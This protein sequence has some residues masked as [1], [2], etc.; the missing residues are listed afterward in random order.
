MQRYIYFLV[1]FVFIKSVPGQEFSGLDDIVN[2]GIKEKYY[3]GAQLLIG[4]DEKILYIKS[5]GSFTYED[6]TNKVTNESIFDLASLT[7]VVATTTAIM[8]LFEEGKITGDE[9]IKDYI[10]EFDNNGKG[11]IRLSNL[12]LHNSGLPAWK[13]FYKTCKTKEDVLNE[14][15]NSELK[16]PVG[17]D[18][19]YSDLNIVILG[20]IVEIIT[21]KSLDEY[22][23]FEIFGKL[24][25][26]N[27]KFKIN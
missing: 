9:Y 22:C 5:Y 3:P 8:L 14:I 16:Y 10:Q 1:F 25:M 21:G 7:K 11:E 27:T 24:G 6:E 26:N 12:L 15:F 20:R 19:L 2:F 18:F 23:E 17:S 13:P 4:D